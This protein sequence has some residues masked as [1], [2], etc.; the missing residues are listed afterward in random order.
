MNW[1][2]SKNNRQEGP[3]SAE[4]IR[5]KISMGELTG[6][7]LAWS[8]GMA[9]WLPLSKISEFEQAFA[10][11]E[12]VPMDL[13]PSAGP[14]DVPAYGTP[15]PSYAPQQPVQVI[16]VKESNGLA[17]AAMIC[18]ILALVTFC[19][20]CTAIPLGIAAV[21]MGHI[22]LARSKSPHYA[23]KGRGLA[24]TGLITGYLAVIVCILLTIG[25]N[26]FIQ[27]TPEEMKKLGMPKEFIEQME[28]SQ[29][30]QKEMQ[31]RSASPESN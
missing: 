3:V 29:Q 14:V 23:G 4:S 10:P 15:A 11:R 9:D 19:I 17:I 27:M 16:V 28:K 20:W 1:Y 18:G 7:D 31:Q 6:S 12:A 26:K 13:P 5:S 30:I 21:I 8:E 25:A 24:I 22:G 2:Y